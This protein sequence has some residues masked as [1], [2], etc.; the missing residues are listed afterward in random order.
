MISLKEGSAITLGI[1]LWYIT[2]PD[3]SGHTQVCFW[4]FSLP[5]AHLLDRKLHSTSSD[6]LFYLVTQK[7]LANIWV[8]VKVASF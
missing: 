5:V 2:Y 7:S 1:S 3:A 6:W 8:V 4:Q